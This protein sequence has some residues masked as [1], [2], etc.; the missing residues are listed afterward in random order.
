MDRNWLLTW[1]TYGTWLPGDRRGSVRRQQNV[2][3]TPWVEST[4]ALENAALAAMKDPPVRLD[5]AQARVVLDQF[6]QTATHRDWQL[7]AV[8]VMHNHVHIVVGVPGDPAP[9][10][11]LRDFKSY[12][13]RALNRALSRSNSG[14]R[15]WWTTSGSRRKLPDAAAVAAAV[16]YV[17][18]QSNPLLVWVNSIHAKP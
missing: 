2:V 11:L 1:T 15:A 18:R 3:G 16:R 6:H 5:F 8:A 13:S 14:P 10:A 9:D 17:E 12:A 7:H 4:P